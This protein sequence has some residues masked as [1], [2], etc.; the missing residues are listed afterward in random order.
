MLVA[1]DIDHQDFSALVNK[2]YSGDV[3]LHKPTREHLIKAFVYKRHGEVLARLAVYHNPHLV[4]N[5]HNTATIGSYECVD[6][7]AV[8][9][10]FLQSIFA[11]LHSKA[12]EFVIGPMEGST[13]H[14]YRF[15]LHNSAPNFMMEP[16]HHIY[17]NEHFKK[18]GFSC[19][20]KYCSN[21]DDT[22]LVNKNLE[23]QFESR[24]KNSPFELRSLFYDDFQRELLRI[25]QFCNEAFAENFLFT[26]MDVEKVANYYSALKKWIDPELILILNDAAG[27]MQGLLFCI[28]D[29][30][31]KSEKTLIVKTL[32]RKKQSVYKGAG[33]YML[34][35]LMTK[36]RQKE[37]QRCIHAFMM[38]DNALSLSEK[39]EGKSYKEYML[40]GK[41]L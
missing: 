29:H 20:S 19:I 18:V 27:N 30:L 25:A 5:G 39:I 10:Q 26:P 32:A 9:E 6:D 34:S 11:W 37:Y 23:K 24:H 31:N 35:K 14:T 41:K 8:S 21:L 17:Y 2:L 22:M 7:D 1:V 28:Q 15:S 38:N 3:A 36:A 13:W 16:Y 12:Y 33:A 4:I 40:Y